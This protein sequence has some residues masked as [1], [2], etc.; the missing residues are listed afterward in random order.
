VT[1]NGAKADGVAADEATVYAYDADGNPVVAFWTTATTDSTLN[2]AAASGM[3]G[4]DGTFVL[5][6][7]SSFSGTHMATVTIAGQAAPGSPIALVF[8]TGDVDAVTLAVSPGSAQ[9]VGDRF[10]LSATATDLAGAL[11]AGV[12]VQF[13]VPDGVEFVGGNGTCTT[14]TQGVCSVRVTSKLAGTY[15]VGGT[16]SGGVPLAAAPQSIVFTA[17]S[18]CVQNCTPVDPAH[19]SRV[20][21]IK[22]GANFDGQDRD[23]VKVWA[24]DE[25]GNPVAGQPVASTTSDATLSIQSPITPT[26]LDG[27]ST[28]WYTSSQAGDHLARV[29]VA[30]LEPQGS[31]VTLGFGAGLGDPSKSSF[32]IRPKVSSLTAPLVAGDRDENTYV[33]KATVNDVNGDPVDDETV[34]FAIQPSGP[35]WGGGQQFCQTV[36]G[37]CEVTVSST[38]AGTFSI[39]ANLAKGPIGQAQSVA[40][41]ADEV[42]G[43][44]CTPEPGVDP[45]H[46]T[47][48]EVVVDR[49]AADNVSA[50]V[51]R[52]FVFDRWG[53]PVPNVLVASTSTTGSSDLRIQQG[54]S[55]TGEDG[56]STVSY[57]SKRAGS[58]AAA[59]TV[60]AASDPK[61]PAGSPVTVAFVAGEVCLAPNCVPDPGVPNDRRTRLEVVED[62]QPANGQSADVVRVFAFDRLGNPVAGVPVTAALPPDSEMVIAGSILDTAADGHADIRFTSHCA[63]AHEAAVYVYLDVAGV[64]TEVVFVPQPGGG[65]PPAEYQSSPV[66]LHFVPGDMSAVNS[67]LVVDPATQSVGLE[68]TATFTARDVSEN[69]VAGLPA[70]ELLFESAG[71]TVVSGPVERSGGFYDWVLRTKVA[72]R[73]EVAV[74]AGGIRLTAGVTFTAGEV[75]AARSSL[76]ASPLVQTAGS[77]IQVTVTAR[78]AYGNPVSS[79]AAGDFVVSGAPQPANPGV[80][81]VVGGNFVNAGGGVYTFDVTSTVAGSFRLSGQVRGAMLA[82][83]PVVQFTA[84]DICVEDCEPADPTH[85]SR[86]ELIKNGADH[87]GLDRNIVRV[88]AYDRHGNAVQG[89]PVRST[90]ADLGLAIQPADSITPT[91]E[92]GS[93]TVWYTSLI[94]G[95]HT[96]DVT[97]RGL[98]PDGSP[99]TMGFG[100]NRGDPARSDF[101]ITPEIP[102]TP[103]PLTAG[104][105]ASNTYRVTATVNDV[106]G[107]PVTGAIVTFAAN[108]AGPMWGGPDAASSCQTDEGT[109]QVT[110]FS[111]RAGPY[112]LGAALAGGPLPAKAIAWSADEVCG[113]EC[114]PEVELP[115]ERRTR[116]EV[117]RDGQT[118]DDRAA[119]LVT[120]YAFDRWGNPIAGQPVASSSA[121]G[122]LRIEPVDELTD[123]NGQA[124]IRYYSKVAG[125]YEADVLVGEQRP[126]DSPVALHFVAGGGCVA[127]GC[128][129]DPEVPEVRWTRVEVTV[130][131]QRADGQSEN[132]ARVHVFDRLGNPVSGV[133]L[134]VEPLHPSLRVQERIPATGADGHAEFRMTSRTAGPHDARV[135]VDIDGELVEV[136]RVESTPDSLAA[137]APRRSSPITVNFTAGHPCVG[138]GCVPEPDVPNDRRTRIDVNPDFQHAD[139][140]AR[141]VANVHL[142]DAHGNAVAGAVVSSTTTDADL[143]V[144]PAGTIAVTSAAG[145]AQVWYTSAVHG[146]HTARVFAEVDGETVEVVF[147]PQPNAAVPVD[148]VSSPIQL[149]F[150]DVTDPA[151]PVITQP[152]SGDVLS[153]NRPTIHGVGEP[154]AA[155]TVRAGDEVLCTT[156]VDPD[157][158]WSCRSETP[159]SDGDHTLTAIQTDAAHLTS[160]PSAPVTV[161]VDTVAPA[162]PVVTQPT[163][164][165]VVATSTP[166][167]AGTAEPDAWITVTDEAGR[168]LCQV[169]ADA[170]GNWSCESRPLTDGPH[171]V[172]AKALDRAGNVSDSAVVPFIVDTTP[173]AAGSLIIAAPAEGAVIHEATPLITGRAESGNRVWVREGEVELC[174]ATADAAGAWLCRVADQAA[175]ADGA[176]TIAAVQGD[177]AGHLSEPV[178]RSFTVHLT[179]PD[180]PLVTYPGSGQILGENQPTVVGQTDP[181]VTVTIEDAD[182]SR[183]TTVADDQGG[184][185]C[186]WPEPWPDGPVTIWAT[187]IDPDGHVSG[188]TEV[189]FT[190]DT[191]PPSAPAP[192]VS[193]PGTITGTGDPGNAIEV[194]DSDGRQ[195]CTTTVDAQGDWSCRPAR[196][197]VPGDEVTATATDEAGHSA[198]TTVRVLGLV[199]RA[200]SVPR[201][202]EQTAQGLYFQPGER[203]RAQ[204]HSSELDLGTL[205]AG[206]DGTVVFTW[207]IPADTSLGQHEVVLTGSRSG[208]VKATFI[209]GAVIPATGSAVR[210]ELVASGGWA[211]LIGLGYLLLAYR[212][213]LVEEQPQK[214]RR[215]M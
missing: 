70:S 118:A 122:D 133:G 68:V 45:A 16:Y 205:E 48:V 123:V 157:G 37:T 175:L 191:T 126:L 36:S 38:K 3:T 206:P 131:H 7:T 185:A 98:T 73:Y 19:V 158:F 72:G 113:A 182:G 23:I 34:T 129:P 109:C 127:P 35:V 194:T 150:V 141:D 59:V 211:C 155:L 130:D 82:D 207:V 151:A 181:G 8:A 107:D 61:V 50:D 26:G 33:V 128:V 79:L 88:W 115:P 102:G 189:E 57:Y 51:A 86:V 4:V 117:T 195:L 176:H 174:T 210:P 74:S 54:I 14:N 193:D 203:V 80:A 143:S 114:D 112:T 201:G 137:L 172:E 105:Q 24:Y 96:A 41:R 81:G 20:E 106:F 18:V 104:D 163:A 192:D 67:S 177:A 78:D 94:A 147:T 31:P 44:D 10:T 179:P 60:G 22:N 21:V 159:L 56:Q 43:V 93:T 140:Q 119:D 134:M 66:T 6:Y 63:G 183:C 188:P 164:G 27:S 154:E 116:V 64:P 198:S 25:L 71:L 30:G 124:V 196:P 168:E 148:M 92:D 208:S 5:S 32:T 171:E 28:V 120:A 209:V 46:T 145:L 9:T 125:R 90:T 197:L 149:N 42:C 77:P 166:N 69:A 2:I 170:D 152:S 200:G 52:V 15:E 40:W 84:G 11:V 76:V 121:A 162:A 190:V 204:M 17:G 212:R 215:A 85:V 49:Q 180:P 100:A 160:V 47:R 213:R 186:P 111:T 184:F 153:D 110:V 144:Q 83:H 135:F 139:G 91:G 12:P 97:V 53:N 169:A 161:L 199:L 55:P 1:K 87:D 187:A 138:P 13:Q 136:G 165:Q 99:V 75:D 89:Q 132:A 167:I 39:A 95:Y 202:H 214:A 103:V 62:Y 156:E 65:E 108:P 146:D 101:T 29:T 178:T 173:P 142:F 58:Y